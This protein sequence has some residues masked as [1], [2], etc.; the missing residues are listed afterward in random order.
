MSD[1][2]TA[3][4]GRDNLMQIGKPAGGCGCGGA[5]GCGGHGE[6][7]GAHEHGHHS[8]DHFQAKLNGPT[9]AEAAAAQEAQA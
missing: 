8:K 5:C 9:S 7:E 1:R 6:A 4:N 3:P 2:D